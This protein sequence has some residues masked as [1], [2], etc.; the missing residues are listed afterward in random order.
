MAKGV[1]CGEGVSL[2]T[3]GI[4]ERAVPL[5]PHKISRYAEQNLNILCPAWRFFGVFILFSPSPK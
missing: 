5:P 4:W 2:P 3:G 1:G